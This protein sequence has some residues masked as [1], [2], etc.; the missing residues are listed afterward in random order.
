MLLWCGVLGPT[1][2]PFVTGKTQVFAP[3]GAQVY[4]CEDNWVMHLVEVGHIRAVFRNLLKTSER[5]VYYKIGKSII[6]TLA[7]QKTVQQAHDVETTSN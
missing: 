7:V 3:H 5:G 2:G 6:I 1:G 4:P